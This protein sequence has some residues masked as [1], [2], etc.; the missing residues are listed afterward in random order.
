MHFLDFYVH[1]DIMVINYQKEI[2]LDL[3]KSF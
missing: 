2:L 1:L 3:K